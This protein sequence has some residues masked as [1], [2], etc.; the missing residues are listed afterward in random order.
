MAYQCPKH[1]KNK[2]TKGDSSSKKRN[3]FKALHT[4]FISKGDWIIDSGASTHTSNQ[5]QLFEKSNEYEKSHISLVDDSKLIIDGKD[6]INLDISL[7]V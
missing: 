5:R 7:L 2:D 6:D 1:K 3:D 4:D